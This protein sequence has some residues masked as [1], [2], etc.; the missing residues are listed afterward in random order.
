MRWIVQ[1]PTGYPASSIRVAASHL[2][3]TDVQH[4]VRART[5]LSS[6]SASHTQKQ[7]LSEKSGGNSAKLWTHETFELFCRV[8]REAPSTPTKAPVRS[9]PMLQK[10]PPRTASKLQ[11]QSN[12]SGAESPSS[13][14]AVGP[15]QNSQPSRQ[16]DC[17]SLWAE[18]LGAQASAEDCKQTTS[19]LRRIF[20]DARV[21]SCRAGVL[22]A[23]RVDFDQ[24][25]NLPVLGKVAASIAFA[26]VLTYCECP[27][28]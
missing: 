27:V 7:R 13:P 19:T 25:L 2:L 22:A 1:E 21:A 18:Q 9:T 23:R 28:F 5:G 12:P 6:L 10:K 24:L 16:A 26:C 4:L 14:L 8:T 11:T 17:R 15:L 3:A 20:R